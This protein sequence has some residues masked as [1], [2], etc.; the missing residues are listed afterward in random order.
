M[1][2]LC[3]KPYSIYINWED[4]RYIQG[5][6]DRNIT[7]ESGHVDWIEEGQ[8]WLPTLDVF[9][10]IESVMLTIFSQTQ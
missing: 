9:D 2:V 4:K 7:C 3:L 6:E 10:T 5:N 1:N 8:F